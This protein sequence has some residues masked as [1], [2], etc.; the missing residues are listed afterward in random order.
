MPPTLV[1]QHRFFGKP[2]MWISLKIIER[3]KILSKRPSTNGCPKNLH[4]GTQFRK[5]VSI[6]TNFTPFVQLQT[7]KPYGTKIDH[8]ETTT[9]EL[10]YYKLH[11]SDIP[12]WGISGSANTVVTKPKEL[13]FYW[14][15]AV[16]GV[17]FDNELSVYLRVKF[18]KVV[19]YSCPTLRI[20]VALKS[21]L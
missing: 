16:C 1:K 11:T 3:Q 18:T 5:R 2:P 17:K 12:S 6:S 21:C 20:W 7:T 10:S 8:P 4:S 14:G 13:I 15:V 9:T 19:G